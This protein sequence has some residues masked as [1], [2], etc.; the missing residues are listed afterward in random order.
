MGIP[1]L[2]V[3]TTTQWLGTARI[4]RG[5]AR[6]GFDV[7]LLTPQGSLAEA[8]RH[9][10]TVHA[11]PHRASPR[12]FDL[13]LLR[14]I[15]RSSP[16][17]LVPCDDMAFR[18]LA[19]IPDGADASVAKDLRQRAS[20]LVVESRGAP[21]GY[22]TSVD[23]NL[24]PAHAVALG[25]DVPAHAVAARQVD[26]ATFAARRGFPVVLKRAHA[27]AGQGVA[28]CDGPA[29]LAAAWH[30][31]DAANREDPLDPMLSRHLLQ[32]V[33][34][35]RTQYF[36]A[37][38]WKGA[39]CAGWALEKLV[40][41]PDPTGPPTVSRWF[42]SPAL[43][44]IAGRLIA[45]LGMTGLLFAEFIVGDDERP[46]LIEVNRRVSPATHRGEARGVDF[47]AALYA[48][49]HDTPSTSRARLDAH[50]SGISVHFPQ[51]WLRDPRS[52]WLS[53][54]PADVPWDEPALLAAMLRLRE[55]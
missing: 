16:R 9:V 8:S 7:S 37:C 2:L 36:H 31:F 54:Y 18:L 33:V 21:G 42:H 50:E 39:L 35:G 55:A 17:L 46:L 51:E 22:R 32:A 49:L 45:G 14:A 11:L 48:A 29:A 12:E 44:A 19:R 23:K 38:A 34:R 24:Q 26:A 52:H 10:R 30:A 5:L 6:A 40:A 20:G 47:C 3:S 27:F 1:L 43:E 28:I 13:Q 53:E 4:P 25:I 15:D 41:H